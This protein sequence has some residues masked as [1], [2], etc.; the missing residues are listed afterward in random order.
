MACCMNGTILL[1]GKLESFDTMG[2]PRITRDPAILSGK[3]I[4]TGTRIT[5]E[6]ILRKLSD[7][8]TFDEILESYPHLGRDDIRAALAF[9]A[10]EMA[11]RPIRAAE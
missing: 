9:A 11:D 6:L 1:Q 7:G 10:D 5:V 3:P 2:H 8:W 4:V